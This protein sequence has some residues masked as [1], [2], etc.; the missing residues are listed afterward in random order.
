VLYDDGANGIG[1]QISP[2]KHR[3]IRYYV[4]KQSATTLKL[5]TSYANAL[6]NTTIDLTTTGNNAQ[7]LVFLPNRDFGGDRPSQA[8]AIALLKSKAPARSDGMTLLFGGSIGKTSTT[9]VYTI[10][11]IAEN[12]ENRG[13][14][15]TPR[16]DASA[17]TDKYIN[18][19]VKF[20]N[21]KTAEDKILFKCRTVERDDRLKQL[22]T[23]NTM[24]AT[25]T[26]TT[27]FTTTAD[28]SLAKVGDEVSF[29]SGTQQGWT[30]HI[31]VLSLNTGT[32]TV[33]IDETMQNLT[34][35]DTCLFTIDNWEKEGT[36]TS[37]D[38]ATYATKSGSTITAIGG[39]KTF[40]VNKEASWFQLKLELR[41]EDVAIEDV[42]INNAPLRQFIA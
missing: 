26:S 41:G 10:N 34:V 15:V 42:L 18:V 25:F 1:T 20:K 16:L 27:Q 33:T 2:L 21:I 13:S 29:H 5:A 22:D 31:T 19:T 8:S 11:A 7:Y 30:A 4:V 37:S 17:I 14:L 6:A 3:Y 38:V 40:Q 9:S 23:A 12:Q 28:L 36:I 24:L 35:N 32:Y 39:A